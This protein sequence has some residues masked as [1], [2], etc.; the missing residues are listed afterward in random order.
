MTRYGAQGCPEGDVQGLSS[1][2]HFVQ[3][4]SKVAAGLDA[5]LF[6]GLVIAAAL[7]GVSAKMSRKIFLALVPTFAS[8]AEQ[9]THTTQPLKRALFPEHQQ[10]ADADGE[11]H[12]SQA[13]AIWTQRA[14]GQ[15]SHH[16][17]ASNASQLASLIRSLPLAQALRSFQAPP[18]P[19]GSHSLP[20]FSQ[21]TVLLV[22]LIKALPAPASQKDAS[23][24]SIAIPH[25]ADMDSRPDSAGL[26]DGSRP[27]KSRAAQHQLRS[28]SAGKSLEAS[29]EEAYKRCRKHMRQLEAGQLAGLLRF[30]LLQGPAPVPGMN[31]SRPELH[32]ALRLRVLQDGVA[33]IMRLVD[34]APGSPQPP[35]E[36]SSWPSSSLE[37]AWAH[38]KLVMAL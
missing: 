6:V 29:M 33:A 21:S 4:A 36:V 37:K 32:G 18:D 9:T 20:S 2:A 19:A 14:F 25:Q 10:Q 3:R 26:A 11:L 28:T 1:A 12:L 15:I 17:S 22:Y 38:S 30:W 8:A 27:D 34:K 16:V 24:T 23:A 35:S 5:R 13:A 7:Q 31:S